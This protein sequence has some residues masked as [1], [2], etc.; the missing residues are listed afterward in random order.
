[1]AAAVTVLVAAALSGA[2]LST[3]GI[4]FGDVLLTSFA[5]AAPAW[6]S[7]RA[8]GV[9]VLVGIVAAAVLV[10]IRRLS[11]GS[12]ASGTVAF[13]PALLVG[14]VVAMVIG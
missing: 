8:A 12:S 9:T 7:P 10:V 14:W 1:M 13:G 5:V 3:R 2:W 6:L 4:A 11:A